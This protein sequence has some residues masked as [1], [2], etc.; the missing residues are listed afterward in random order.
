MEKTGGEVNMNFN[1]FKKKKNEEE[2]IFQ[3]VD[4][5]YNC[6]SV[7]PII[8]DDLHLTNLSFNGNAS[9]IIEGKVVFNAKKGYGSNEKK[10]TITINEPVLKTDG[11]HAEEYESIITVSV[12]DNCFIDYKFLSG[13]SSNDESDYGKI[14]HYYSYERFVNGDVSVIIGEVFNRKHIR[15]VINKDN[16]KAEISLGDVNFRLDAIFQKL[17]NLDINE[18]YKIIKEVSSGL[19][20]NLGI[21]ITDNVLETNE[22]LSINDGKIIKYNKQYTENGV[23]T[24][25]SYEEGKLVKK[26]EL[27]EDN[28]DELKS[29]DVD[30]KDMVV[31]IKTLN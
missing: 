23:L 9:N 2:K 1:I 5:R 10:Y 20:L 3:F 4:Y 7:L 13:K 14:Y 11:I 30:I 29:S 22:E 19:V 16:K 18:I 24:S 21:S 26:T 27:I 28:L 6:A 31:K 25:L 17:E 8:M 12:N 15:Y